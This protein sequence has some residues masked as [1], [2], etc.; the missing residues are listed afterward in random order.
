[1]TKRSKRYG[2]NTY[3]PIS[4]AVVGTSQ[5][6]TEFEK[7]LYKDYGGSAKKARDTTARD[8]ASRGLKIKKYSRI[9]LGDF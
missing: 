9:Y 2:L 5:Y 4:G 7:T 8:A 1:M 3:D 6:S